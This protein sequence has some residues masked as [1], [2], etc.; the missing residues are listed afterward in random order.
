VCL[1]EFMDN[2]NVNGFW[3]Y[4]TYGSIYLICLH[5]QNAIDL[6]SSSLGK[7]NFNLDSGR[8]F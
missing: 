7:L 2:G 5:P 8:C 3:R 6:R 1:L 4:F